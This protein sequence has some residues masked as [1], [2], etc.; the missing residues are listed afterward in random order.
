MN[1]FIQVLLFIYLLHIY[2]MWCSIS[3]DKLEEID[4]LD[5]RLSYSQPTV[6]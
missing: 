5:P 4:S 2:S 6:I 1:S 3:N